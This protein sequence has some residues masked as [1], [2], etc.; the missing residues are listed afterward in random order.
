MVHRGAVTARGH[1]APGQ[2]APRPPWVPGYAAYKRG[3]LWSTR[4]HAAQA[5]LATGP[6][7]AQARHTRERLSMSGVL[8]LRARAASW[9]TYGAPLAS[10]LCVIFFVRCSWWSVA[11][12]HG[13]VRLSGNPYSRFLCACVL[14]IARCCGW[15][16]DHQPCAVHGCQLWQRGGEGRMGDCPA[17]CRGALCDPRGG[18]AGA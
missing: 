15:R 18:A 8:R 7:S 1:H 10:S 9:H 5:Q 4:T 2:S 11:R 12:R 17:C 16:L 3:T 14:G 13:C 6:G